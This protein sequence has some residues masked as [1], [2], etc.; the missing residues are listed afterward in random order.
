MFK[1]LF[2]HRCGFHLTFPNGLTLSTLIGVGGFCT[3]QSGE[4]EILIFDRNGN[5]LT[6]TMGRDLSIG[7]AGYVLEH[8]DMETWLKIIDW[9]RNYRV[10]PHV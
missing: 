2:K 9:C 4:S 3:I 7:G 1:V 5:S 10:I 8:V 6:E